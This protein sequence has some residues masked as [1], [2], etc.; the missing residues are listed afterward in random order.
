MLELIIGSVIGAIISLVIA[1][2]YWRRS[3]YGLRKEVDRLHSIQED[4]ESVLME[5]AGDVTLAKR[6]IGK[7]THDDPDFPYK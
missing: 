6:H 1:E 7:G 3:S 5:V 4:I 2:V